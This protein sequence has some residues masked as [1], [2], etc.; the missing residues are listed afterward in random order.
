MPSLNE[1][2]AV[3]QGSLATWVC[4]RQASLAVDEEK[5]EIARMQAEFAAHAHLAVANA[6]HDAEA[7]AQQIESAPENH[8][9]ELHAPVPDAQLPFDE[10]AELIARVQLLSDH[11]VQTRNDLAAA[12]A[13]L[14]VSRRVMS[15][16]LGSRVYNVLRLCGRWRSVEKGIQRSLR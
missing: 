5:G 11:L 10:R 4:E 8:T 6:F 1:Y 9:Y 16:I 7:L 3:A 12:R 13:T 15:D 2:P 14:S